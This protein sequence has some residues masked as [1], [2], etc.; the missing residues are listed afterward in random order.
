[1]S[2]L[3]H[4]QLPEQKLSPALP[5]V[6]ELPAAAACLTCAASVRVGAVLV[7]CEPDWETAPSLNK[8]S[9]IRT[10]LHRSPSAAPAQVQTGDRDRLQTAKTVQQ[11]LVPEFPAWQFKVPSVADGENWISQESI[12][13]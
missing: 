8:N 2:Q 12:R 11:Q 5:L 6:S 7:G 9:K 4:W 3:T 1:M 13:L 10:P